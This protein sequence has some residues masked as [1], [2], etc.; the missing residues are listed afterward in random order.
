[1]HQF[2]KFKL[3]LHV[4]PVAGAAGLMARMAGKVGLNT[5]AKF[6]TS[7][8]GQKALE[9]GL[10]GVI[11]SIPEAASEGGNSKR[12]LMDSGMSEE[13]AS[14]KAKEVYYKNLAFLPVSNA[15]ESMLLLAMAILHLMQARQ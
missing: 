2:F 6:I 14:A 1:M 10:G 3:Q 15:I 4:A 11:R 5:A 12:D 13:E 9:L 8:A 7:Q